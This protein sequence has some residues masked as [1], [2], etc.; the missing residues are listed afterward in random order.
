VR[1]VC[2]EEVSFSYT[3]TN[4]LFMLYESPF[5]WLV[6]DRCYFDLQAFN[7]MTLAG[8]NTAVVGCVV[9]VT[10]TVQV[11]VFQAATD[12]LNYLEENIGKANVKIYDN[13][14]FIGYNTASWD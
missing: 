8:V 1:Q 6:L 13:N 4:A 10:Q 14:T 7:F 9:N 3:S 2:F 12:C 11:G 5:K